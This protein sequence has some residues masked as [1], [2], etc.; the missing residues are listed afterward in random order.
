MTIV[1][2]GQATAA[3]TDD[4]QGQPAAPAPRRSRAF[5]YTLLGLLAYV[6]ALLTAPGKVAADT[7]QY[8]YL[9]PGRLLSR[10]PSMWDPN[11]GLGTV[12]HQNIGY[13]FPMGPY[14]WLMERLGSPDWVAQRIWL[15]SLIFFAGLGVLYLLRTLDVRG[16]GTV[17]AA[18]AFMLSPY[19]LHYAARISVILLPWAGLPWLLAIMIRA[20]RTPA[21]GG[22]RGWRYPAAFA[23]VVQIIGGVNATALV[24]ALIAPL[25]WLPYAM[26]IR[27]EI[28]WR[29][30]VVTLVKVGVL[31]LFTSLWW[32][33]GLWV[34]GAYGINI[35]RYTETVKTVSTAGVAPEVLRGL[36]YWFFYGG[37]KVGQWIEASLNY[38]QR[39]WL[40]LVS[41]GVPTTALLAAA[42][43]RWR[44]RL[45][46]AV[47]V[48]FGLAIA[49][50][51]HPYDDPSPFG[52]LLKAFA[53]RSSAGLALRSV[54]RAVPLVALGLAVLLGVGVNALVHR[55]DAQTR[56]RLGGERLGHNGWSLVVIG[57]IVAL[58]IVNLPALWNDTFYGQNLQR[59]EDVPDYWT[60]AAAA[61]DAQPHTTR[62]LEIPGSDFASY[63][64]G[65]TVD[66]ITPGLMD[67]PYVARELIPYGNPP[68]N[69]LLNALDRRLQEDLLDP[70][71]LAP[72]ARLMSVGDILLRSD[73]QVDRYNLVR[74]RALWQL[75]DP[76][77]AGLGEPEEFGADAG[78]GPPLEFPLL[79]E[80]ELAFPAGAAEPPPVAIFPV[81]DVPPIVRASSAAEPVIVAG[82]GEGIVEMAGL[83][84]VDDSA[85]LLYSATFAGDKP[86]LESQLARE[87]VLVVTDTNRR[88]ARRWSTVREN[89]G[90][91]ERAG[92]TPLE[93][94]PSDARLEV[95][96]EAGD[97][98]FTVME[99]IGAT[100]GASS[101]GNRISYTPED[102]P[103]R[104]VDGD[105]RTAWR[106]AGF[107]PTKGERIVIE[108]E[109]PVTTDHVNVVQPLTGDRNRWITRATLRF[110]DGDDVTVDLGDA[111]R[112]AEGQTVEFSRRTIR[113]LEIVVE[114]DNVGPRANFIGTSAV[115]FAEIRIRDDAPGA[116]DVRVKEVARMPTDLTG[117][118]GAASLDHRLVYVM[119]RARTVLIPPRGSEDELA[120][121]RIFEV[122][123]ARDFTLRGSA[124]LSTAVADEV[125]DDLL[126]LPGADVSGGMTVRSSERLPGSVAA[127]A[128]SAVDGDVATS[129][130][131]RFRAP[132]G[133][134]IE[135]EL[136]E[137]VTVDSIDLQLV[138]DGR[139]SV[140]TRLRIDAGG[141]TRV[142]DVPAIEDEEGE[143]A[144][145]TVPVAFEPVTASTIRVT[146]EAVREVETIEYYSDTSIVTPVAI[147]EVGIPGVE[148]A[149]LPATLPGE[150]RSDLLALDGEP[151]P[152]RLAGEPAAAEALTP[153][154]VQR[155]DPTTGATVTTPIPL[156]EGDHE[157]SAV[158]GADTGIDLD[159]LVLGSEAGGDALV[160]GENG[161]VPPVVEERPGPPRVEVVESGRTNMKLEVAGGDE[162]FWLVLGESENTGWE[163][164][165]DG[166]GMGG[167]ILVNGYANGWLVEPDGD[168]TMT[169]TLTWTPQ[170]TVWIAIAISALAMLLCVALVLGFVVRRRPAPLSSGAQSAP[171]SDAFHA[172][173]RV[174][175]PAPQL[176]VPWQPRGALPSRWVRVLTPPL[177]AIVA[178]TL[179]RPLAG[180]LVGV[181]VLAAVYRPRWRTVLALGAPA[182]LGLAGL[183]VFVQQWRHRYPGVFEWPTFFDRVHVLGWLAVAFLAAD[184]LVEAVR[185]AAADRARQ[186]QSSS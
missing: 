118:A 158:A 108:L 104:A 139:H 67:R 73:L 43:V 33:A 129:W 81:E 135:V 107:A 89:V 41:Y 98:A 59:P 127:R 42:F 117:T 60:E 20:L 161:I 166:D 46:F 24:F 126:G 142:V 14:Y 186:S 87:A 1:A 180:V 80:R 179:I 8:L 151:V 10:A 123:A 109:E 11:I 176:V 122:P 164:S 99:Q 183:Y 184:V 103:V 29:R 97:D 128:S 173:E 167:S 36:G 5:G 28:D 57:V 177:A 71:A 51:T 66:P 6:P 170:R 92:E 13:L 162:P 171:E 136:P 141:E 47:L 140:P 175:E 185:D 72:I 156:D 116:Q 132:G 17:V 84:L 182:A 147:A 119:S 79:D 61:L 77:P 74:P 157:L 26:W 27:R 4:G 34:Q 52:A 155:C 49:V 2:P 94:D 69:D 150:C 133:Q 75:L 91:T 113:R 154:D 23:V 65:N 112:A 159:S 64:W 163:A 178:G 152:I 137:P 30:A 86:E 45:Y 63:R 145:V 70:A 168:G 76:P 169:I 115:G 153:L 58:I 143:N 22:W 101:Y 19:S 55:L 174:V 134:W 7:K 16:P 165:V 149:P 85:L 44:H 62:V 172:P 146:V 83:G 124:R 181:L 68:T 39:Q 78:L 53:D 3:T 105:L 93:D 131:T 102:R 21:G 111:S 138:A 100:V 50:G 125:V 54:G 96:P 148:R 144:T 38:T 106:G 130:S 37:D 120:L 25:L 12:T 95:F 9:D 90:Y 110:D 48:L 121:A 160:L 40:I 56:Y 18:L 15:G 82:D 35:L 32:L 114:D 88:R 31:T